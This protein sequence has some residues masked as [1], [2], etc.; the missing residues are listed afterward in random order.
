MILNVYRVRLGY[1]VAAKTRAT[2]ELFL[3]WGDPDPGVNARALDDFRRA[4]REEYFGGFPPDLA[5]ELL[6]IAHLGPA[7]VCPR[8][9]GRP[10]RRDGLLAPEDGSMAG[11]G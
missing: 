7:V 4:I 10:R 11:G 3:V 8:R 2:R 9:R 6:E 1:V 5:L